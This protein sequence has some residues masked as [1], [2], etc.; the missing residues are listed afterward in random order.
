M[1]L[2]MPLM[3]SVMP[4]SSLRRGASLCALS[5]LASP[6]LAQESLP[7]IDIHSARPRVHQ[8]QSHAQLTP[9]PA[10]IPAEA[11]AAEAAPSA[12]GFGP[13][14][15]KLPIYRD[16]PGQ[17]VTD[18]SHKIISTTPTV[19][20]KELLQFSPGVDVKQ[21]QTPREVYISI[22]GS[23]NRPNSGYP[24]GVR[25]VM[26][27]EDGFQIVTADGNV[28]TDILD[29]HA[30]TAVDVYR[31]PSS[32]LFG[33]YATGGAVNFRSFSGAQID[34][35]ETGSE[36]GSF[37][38]INNYVRAGKKLANTGIGD[39]DIAFFA[40]D[41]RGQS[42]IAHSAY[43]YNQA[44]I[45][46][47]WTPTPTDRFTVKTVVNDTFAQ[48]ANTNSFAQYYLNPFQQSYAC[49]IPTSW[50]ASLC[51]NLGVPRNGSFTGPGNPTVI[52]SVGELGTH[53]H[54]DQDI[55]GARWEHDLDSTTTW[56]SQVTYNYLDF[57]A[58]LWTPPKT[59][60]AASGG[61]GGPIALRG[62]SV[63]LNAITDITSRMPL[64]GLPAIH[65]VAFFWDD[66][67]TTEWLYPQL[68]YLWNYGMPGGLVGKLDYEQ[69][70]YSIRAREELALTPQLTA[71]A[72]FSSN[73]DR[74]WGVNTVY[75][76]NAKGV[77]TLPT[78]FAIDKGFWNTAPE[79]SLTYRY[80]PEWQLRTRFAGGYGTPTF[81]YLTTTRNG[82]GLN[83]GLRPQTN[84]GLDV[85]IDW[86]PTKDVTVSVTG[87][88]E[89]FRN[90]I[91]NLASGIYI[92]QANIPASQHRGAEVNGEWRPIEG[93][94]L[95]AA[96]TYNDQFITSYW[97]DLG[98]VAGKPVAY[99]RAGNKV[100]NAPAHT[101][102]ARIGY[103]Q[104]VGLFRGLGAY[105]EYVYKSSYTIDN[106]N[107]TT[108]PS[109]G[110]V[111]LNLHYAHDVY[112]SY[113]KN[114]E[115]YFNVSNLFDGNYVAR[116]GTMTNQ[117]I[118]GTV[119]QANA[120]LLATQLGAGI[121]PG[122]PRSFSAGLKLKF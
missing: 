99:N 94:K 108:V 88:N 11:P 102:T 3:E 93:A 17:T 14:R 91:L 22:R 18:L 16:P 68:P 45:L 31:G 62:P 58:G 72:G 97:D 1:R 36:F 116:A 19:S 26:M 15:A 85:G 112:D 87:F 101:A 79:A 80:S 57:P 47:N 119:I 98:L 107:F 7:T 84:L 82:A 8:Q 6:S 25:N 40:S 38:Y 44:K 28:R 27:Y 53:M 122:Q 69:N 35:F 106:A 42:Y 2:C 86:T 41:A 64:F 117:L 52:Q 70:N 34:G 51:P 9:A 48:T 118:A 109:Y 65:Y 90:E 78:A 74:I 120:P 100:P 67:D 56:R 43:E 29:P 105:V 95:I 73:W 12:P 75:N 46:A 111:N 104:P 92:Y 33:N 54:I 96:Y 114:F 113:L 83:T 24:Y 76:Y 77:M 81:A 55:V 39:V 13:E 60:P 20:M 23:G 37:G 66:I 10:Q 21:G 121:V 61:L 5:L 115:V 103:D 63:G 4:R 32:A 71:V 89:W 59:G 49:A 30:F 50:N 110:L